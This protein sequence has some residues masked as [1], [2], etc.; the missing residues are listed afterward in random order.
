MEKM[1]PEFRVNNFDLIRIFAASQ[2]M[3]QHS[4]NHLQIP[5]PFW[6]S[7][8]E[9]FQGVP[10]FFVISGYL[11]SSSF[12]RSS[13]LKNYISNRI[14]R[15]YP[16]LWACILLSILT[17]AIFGGINFFNLQTPVWLISQM[18]GI[19]YTP[20]F[21]SGYGFGSY[22][23]SLWTIPI[24]LQFYIVLPVIY[25]LISKINKKN[26]AILFLLLFF[27][28]IAFVFHLSFPD[29]GSINETKT[30]KLFR[31]SFMPQFYMFLTGVA[32]QKFKAYQSKF[33][34][35]KGLYWI[36]AFLLFVYFTPDFTIKYLIASL[37]LSI[38]T[39][40]LAYTLPN[41]SHRLLKG[42]DIS[43]GVYI[44][45][46][47]IL[48]ILV[49]YKYFN[50]LFY[51]FTLFLFTYIIAYF[52]WNYIEKPMLKRKKNTINTANTAVMPVT[53]TEP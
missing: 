18:A 31:Y 48:N 16:G 42:N 22:N 43:Y 28:F 19:I 32:L 24:E 6:L 10:I 52:S 47:I 35:G 50:N 1:K 40:S 9:N 2:V 44:Y 45:H 39:I 34:Y 21:L 14:L 11:I 23:G 26:T 5:F 13:N 36:G 37:V 4:Y 27:I 17:A 38:T 49:E 3:V 41:I 12:E 51:L 30:A 46:G 7:V 29:M 8:F 20:H 33:I 25:L 15:I 53:S